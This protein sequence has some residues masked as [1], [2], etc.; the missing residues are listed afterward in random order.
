MAVR[1]GIAHVSPGYNQGANVLDDGA[2][3][4]AGITNTIKLWASPTY[5]VN[6][7]GQTW[8]GT[9][10][11]LTQLAQLAPYAAVLARPEFTR[12]YLGAWTFANGVN[13]P[14]KGSLS[15]AMLQNEYTELYNFCVHLLSTYSNKDFILQTAES[16]WVIVNNGGQPSFAPGNY[17]DLRLVDRCV[18]FYG[19]RL[20]AVADARKAVAS[21]SRVFSCIETNRVL[22]NGVRIHTHVLPRLQP[23][24]VSWT[25]Y[26]AINEWT[27]PGMN[28]ATA[29]ASMAAKMREVVRRIR[30]EIRKAQGVRGDRIPIVAGEFGWPEAHP[31]FSSTFDAG[32]L[33]AKFLDTCD[34]LGVYDANFWQL[35]DNEVYEDPAPTHPRRQALYDETGAVTAQ[36]AEILA[37]YP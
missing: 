27:L 36:G 31:L 22:D 35:W 17:I 8:G 21:S 24:M 11:N 7:P 9:P 14:W 16:D 29:E 10:T 18:G 15:E 6:Y 2:D 5:L 4:I 13:D 1:L 3:I 37:R 33:C 19:Y 12:Y 23:D 32:A 20:K 34:E 25:S 30:T 28:Q 26:E